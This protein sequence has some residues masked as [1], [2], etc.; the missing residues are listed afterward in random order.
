MVTRLLK[1][2]KK[3]ILLSFL[4]LLILFSLC[5]FKYKGCK[6]Y[7]DLNNATQEQLQTIYGIG[8]RRS[9]NIMLNRPYKDVEDCVIKCNLPSNIFKNKKI[10]VKMMVMKIEQEKNK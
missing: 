3:I 5:M 4:V 10:V 8:E 1:E 9:W 2:N 6:E 7:I